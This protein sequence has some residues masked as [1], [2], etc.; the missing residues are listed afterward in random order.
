MLHAFFTLASDGGEWS[1]SSPVT[2]RYT[3][4][5]RLGGPQGQFGCDGEEKIS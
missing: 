2:P 3:L 4:D 1:T 5:R